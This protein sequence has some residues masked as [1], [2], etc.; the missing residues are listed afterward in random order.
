[1]PRSESRPL[2]CRRD[3]G[4]RCQRAGQ[5]VT[6]GGPWRRPAKRTRQLLYRHTTARASTPLSSQGY[7]QE[8]VVDFVSAARRRRLATYTLGQPMKR[9]RDVPEIIVPH[10]LKSSEVSLKPFH[11][12]G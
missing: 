3:H 2:V 10:R 8:T 11:Y 4:D 6:R 1:M 12:V 7:L 5:D 9:L